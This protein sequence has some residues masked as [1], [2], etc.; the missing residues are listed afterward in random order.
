MV[1]VVGS[2]ATLEVSAMFVQLPVK[3]LNSEQFTVQLLK[4]LFR[5]GTN[6]VHLQ[7][8]ELLKRYK[9]H[10]SYWTVGRTA[11]WQWYSV[12]LAVQLLNRGSGSPVQFTGGSTATVQR[13]WF[14]WTVYKC[15]V[16]VVL[17]KSVEPSVQLLSVNCAG[18]VTSAEE[19]R[20]R[21]CRGESSPV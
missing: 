1:V 12:Q 2:G 8:T 17:L 20:G 16:A 19:V 5:K 14:S 15:T 10:W 13:Q 4:S 6:T 3:L 7:F 21:S 9:W 18:D 11:T